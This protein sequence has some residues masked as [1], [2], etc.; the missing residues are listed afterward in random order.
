[1]KWTLKC[2]NRMQEQPRNDW[3]AFNACWTCCASVTLELSR[4][5][6]GVQMS[7]TRM[8]AGHQY[9]TI[10]KQHR[11]YPTRERVEAQ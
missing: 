1:M 2:M 5:D 7:R 8:T 11:R 9:L 4:S 6:D 3:P 10:T